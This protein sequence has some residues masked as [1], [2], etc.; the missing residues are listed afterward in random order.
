MYRIE[1]LTSFLVG[2]GIGAAGALLLAP[3]SGIR[4]RRRIV[5]LASSTGETL[6]EQA[7]ELGFAAK[8]ATDKVV[9][10]VVDRSGE[11][12]HRMGKTMEEGGKRL[13]QA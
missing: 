5:R 1:H 8:N 11:V 2:L 12:A 7:E 6:R 3:E 13:Q 4:T 10:Q 9:D